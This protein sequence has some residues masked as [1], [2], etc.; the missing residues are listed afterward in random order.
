M[1]L[2]VVGNGPVGQRLVDALRERDADGA[3]QVTVVGEEPR[4]AYDRV[5]LSSYFDG[6][7]A[8]ELDLVADGCYDGT[9]AALHLGETVVGIRRD[10][11]IVTTSRER[12]IGYDALVLATGSYPFVPPVPG[13][14]LPGCF[15]YRT[16]DDLD[17]IRAAAETA[18]AR[19]GGRP[20]AMVVGGG[21][22]GLEAARALRLLGM[23]PHV[24]ELAPRLMPLQVD[25][26]GGSAAAPA[27]RGA[28]RH[29]AHRRLGRPHR[30]RP[31]PAARGPDQRRRPRRRPRRLLRRHPSPRR[32]R[33]DRRPRGRPARRGRRRRRRPHRGRVHLRGRRVREHRRRR[34][35]ARRARLRDG[36]GGGRPATGRGGR[37]PRR[38]HRDEAQADG[39]RRRQLRRRARH[40]AGRA[41]G[42]GQQPGRAQL[43]QARRVRRCV[44]PA[45][46]DLRR[47]RVEIRAAAPAGRRSP[48]RRPA[49]AHRP[50]RRRRARFRRDARLGPGLLVQRRDEGADLRRHRR[51]RADRRPR[52]QG[53]HAGRDDLRLLRPAAQDAARRERGRAEQCS[54]RALHALAARAVRDRPGD[55][56][57]HVHRARATARHRSRL[58][59]LQAGRRLDPGQ[60]EQGRSPARRRAGRAA[61]HQRPLPRQHPEERHLLGGAAH[62]RRRDHAREAARDRRGGPRLRPLHEDHRGAADRPARRA[63]GAAAADL[64]AAW[65]RPVSSPGTRTARRCGR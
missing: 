37:V 18:A 30:S 8:D 57:Q 40:D 4:R 61:G 45:R 14:D 1:R 25:E 22:L 32:T 16:L 54:L 10:A 49:R 56:H 2:C 39:R 11:R 17:A 36:R 41:R 7:S 26:G 29:R 47:R 55:R 65:W 12:S 44:H 58:R 38:R 62:P 42:D 52:R 31:G 50:G 48:A 24:V 3:W 5:A 51:A 21:L 43:R 63:G 20:A 15:V 34:V 13:R 46:R 53:V 28:G 35:R 27:D 19:R 6:V 23:S 59:H 9:G 64:G 60:P 33:P